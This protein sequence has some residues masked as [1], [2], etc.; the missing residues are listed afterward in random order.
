MPDIDMDFG[1]T[2]RGEVVEYVRKNM[3]TTMS[4]DRDL[5]YH[6]RPSSHTGCGPG[7][8]HDLRRGGCCGEAGT[9]RAGALHI[10]LQEALKLSKQL[11]DMYREEPKV[12]KAHRHSHGT[13]GNAAARLYPRSGRSHHKTAGV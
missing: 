5:R 4:P 9:G 10:T 11:A 6:G 3:A 12:K 1:D 13:G 2:R 7:A 8:E